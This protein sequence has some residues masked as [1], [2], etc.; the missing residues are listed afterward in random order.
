MSSSLE[1]M[2]NMIQQL[3]VSYINHRGVKLATF[4]GLIL[5]GVLLYWLSGGFPPWA[6]R[7][8]AQTIPQIGQ[9]WSLHG[10]AILSPLAGLILLS[11]SLLIMWGSLTV[12][13]VKVGTHWWQD[14]QGQRSLEKE[15]QEAEQMADDYISNMRTRPQLESLS[16]PA[17]ARRAPARVSHA[18]PYREASDAYY[19]QEDARRPMQAAVPSYPRVLTPVPRVRQVRYPST[20]AARRE[21]LRLVPSPPR[22]E[23][24]EE[25][26]MTP[27]DLPID[28]HPTL[29]PKPEQ[30]IENTKLAQSEPAN[31]DLESTD[32]ENPD[33]ETTQVIG[34]TTSTR[35][36]TETEDMDTQLLPSPESLQFRFAVGVS[37]DPGIVRRYAPNED[38]LLTMQGTR[39]TDNGPEPV[40][41]FIIADGMGGHAHGQEASRIAIRVLSDTVTPVLMRG[42]E[43][44]VNFLEVLRDGAH[45]ANLAIYQRNREQEETMGT[46][47]T[48]AL[49]VANTAY[50][51]NVGDSRTYH[52]RKGEGLVPVTRDHSVVAR[53]VEHGAITSDEVYTHPQRNQ[54]YRCLGERASVDVDSFTIS[55]YTGD[56]L[57]LCSDGLWEMVRDSD[58]QDIIA[59]SLPHPT[60]IS[61]RLTQAAL[62]HGGVDNI[63]LIVVHITRPV[64]SFLL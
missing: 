11:L 56:V 34:M 38:T 64:S 60:N 8:L 57:L 29:P 62:D 41:L 19:P 44:D 5:C 21:Q 49:V 51:V 53:L 22:P 14:V 27:L 30:D 28:E 37:L 10:A 42:T 63:S 59:A 13:A 36:V 43:H 16:Q 6:W 40:G 23:P 61:K 47:L 3:Q 55:L 2:I 25:D 54:I 12:A 24:S 17:L 45:R 1:W 26:D 31:T 32:L 48:A 20:L 52:Y 58:M 4:A 33:L 35:Q 39:T 9:L 7:F 50:I 18:T 46:T 15:W